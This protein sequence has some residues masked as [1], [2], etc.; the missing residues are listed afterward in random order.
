MLVVRIPLPGPKEASEAIPAPSRDD[1][2]VEVRDALADAVVDG[3]E[4]AVRV[5][6]QFN[7]A[8]Q[9]LDVCKQD[10]G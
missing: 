6:A 3:D 2:D 1:V 4:R 8:R 10:T 7:R 5:Q 9:R